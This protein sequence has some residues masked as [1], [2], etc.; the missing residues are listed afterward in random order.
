MKDQDGGIYYY[1]F[2]ENKAIRMYVK[3]EGGSYLFRMWRR[4]DKTL[5]DD[6]GWVPHEAVLQAADMY[7]KKQFDPKVVYDI[8]IA[9]ALLRDDG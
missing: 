6:H 5:W 3:K 9:K 7:G 8:R 2:P 4:D 1:P